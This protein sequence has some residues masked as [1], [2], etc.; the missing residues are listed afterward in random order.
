LDDLIDT[1]NTQN[2]RKLLN[3]SFSLNGDIHDLLPRGLTSWKTTV[4]A[5]NVS[6]SNPAAQL[7]DEQTAQTQR[8]F[9]KYSA[10]ASHQQ[11]L[12]AKD[13][14]Y[15]ALSG[16]T[17]NTNLDQ[18]QKMTVGGPSSVRAY[19]TG[20]VSGD[21]GALLTIELRHLLDGAVFGTEGQWQVMAFFDS[22]H[23]TINKTPWV[24]GINDVTLSGC[25]VGVVWASS[26]QITVQLTLSEGIGSVPTLITS[27]AAVHA[28]AVVSK[29]F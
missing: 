29:G 17:T 15:V 23:V 13:T 19:D 22:A 4:S 18:S 5:G 6:I 21:H 2:E 10:W 27:N 11:P 24:S 7:A 14:L 28:W 9:V 1:A 20:A 16:Q 12:T 8:N 26:K 3:T 25:G